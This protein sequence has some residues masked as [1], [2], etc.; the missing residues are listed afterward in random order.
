MK[1]KSLAM[2]NYRPYKGFFQ[3][4]FADGGERYDG[5]NLTVIVGGNDFGK[6]N[7]LNAISWCIYGN[8]PYKYDNRINKDKKFKK[9]YNQNAALEL[10]QS[11]TL[12]V[13]VEVTMEINDGEEVL[14]R[15]SQEFKKRNDGVIYKLHDP[16]FSI[17]I[18]S[19]GDDK[20]IMEPNKFRDTHF[21]K[22]LQQYFL[23]DGERLLEWLNT[24]SEALKTAV[25]RLSHADLIGK[26]RKNTKNQSN[27]L[28]EE[29][30]E[31]NFKKAEN[32]EKKNTLENALTEDKIK[33][34]NATK[35][36]EEL[37][38]KVEELE[39]AILHAGGDPASLKKQLD[40]LEK[41][42]E[43][44]NLQKNSIKAEMRDYLLDSFYYIVGYP[45]LDNLNKVNESIN[46]E[47]SSTEYIFE[48]TEKDIDFILSKNECICGNHIK[49][50]S[51]SYTKLIEF[52]NI[53]NKKPVKTFEE[54]QFDKLFEVFSTNMENY[55]S[56]FEEKV[57][58]FY[59]RITDIDEIIDEKEESKVEIEELYEEALKK[60]IPKIREELNNTNKIIGGLEENEKLLKKSIQNTEENLETVNEAIKIEESKE[61]IVTPIDSKIKFCNRIIEICDTLESKFSNS[62]YKQLEDVVNEEFQ[63]IYNGDGNRGKYEKIHIDE[64]LELTFKEVDGVESTVTDPSSGTQLALA[65]SFITAIN[66]ASGFKMPQIMDTSLGR[67]D[68]VLRRNF[69]LT[70][71]K[72]LGKI[73]MVFLFLDS[74]YN[75][76]FEHLIAPYVGEKHVLN[77]E[78]YTET[79]LDDGG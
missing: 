70:L 58:G 48:M 39:D 2:K 9:R 22:G 5:K 59:Q 30:K 1:I 53:L 13:F 63:S 64:S 4:D 26:V 60:K 23:F 31:I 12:E 57:V 41:D 78:N 43:T 6:T 40:S 7:F 29:L 32:L 34:K 61:G 45:L 17:N 55:P 68:T 16:I 8:E 25:G 66:L 28:V 50:G 14:F 47:S 69:A 44:C 73:Q 65:V 71:P 52:K 77:R 46:K 20:K 79:V 21:P 35:E 19:N 36:R 62:I 11:S 56:N 37:E 10:D 15:R 54:K 33:L 38:A 27:D 18:I 3:V 42:L 74:E 67:W 51:D 24:D 49:E 72:Y 76:E 75:E